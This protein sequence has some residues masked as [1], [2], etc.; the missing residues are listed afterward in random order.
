[1]ANTSKRTAGN[2]RDQKKAETRSAILTAA[3]EVFTEGSVIATPVEA[4]AREAGVSKATMFFHFGSRI[5]LLEA[6]ADK[7]YRYGVDHIWRPQGPGLAP[8]LREYLATQ[9]LPQTRVLWEIGDV[10]TASQRPGPDVAYLHL[11][12]EIEGRLADD[13]VEPVMRAALAQLI[14][15]G[16]LFVAR[17]T[18]LGQ[19]DDDELRKFLANVDAIVQPWRTGNGSHA[20]EV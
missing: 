17:R 9:R 20:S 11:I 5:D 3:V 13:G 8:F 1:M 19:A 15:S 6:V 2:R 12:G 16:A 4:V 14:G 10:L 7:I 18:V